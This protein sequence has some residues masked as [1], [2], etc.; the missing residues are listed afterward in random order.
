[1]KKSILCL[2]LLLAFSLQAQRDTNIKPDESGFGKIKLPENTGVNFSSTVTQKYLFSSPS[3][4]TKP[5]LMLRI[6]DDSLHADYDAAHLDEAASMLV[7]EA[8]KMYNTKV[9]MYKHTI[10]SLCHEVAFWKGMDTKPVGTIALAPDGNLYMV[11]IKEDTIP[12]DSLFSVD[13]P[14]S[15]KLKIIAETH[16]SGR[17][18]LNFNVPA[19]QFMEVIENVD[20][21]DDALYLGGKYQLTIYLGVAFNEDLVLKDVRKACE[22]YLRNKGLI[23]QEPEFTLKIRMEPMYPY[24]QPDAPKEGGWYKLIFNQSAL[25]YLNIVKETLGVKWASWAST[26]TTE[27]QDTIYVSIKNEFLATDVLK[28]IGGNCQAYYQEHYGK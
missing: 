28:A 24:D 19:K 4:I 6:E 3:A 1:M 26:P 17:I 5:I 16:G 10:D 15:E 27:V 11:Q 2:L 7:K 18:E 14:V 21:V 8:E 23:I 9:E 20:G 13:E 25:Q 22:E 12:F